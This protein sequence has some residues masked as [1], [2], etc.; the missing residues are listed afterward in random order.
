MQSLPGL[1][2][3][4]VLCSTW[5]GVGGEWDS[6]SKC[7]GPAAAFLSGGSRTGM[8]GRT[9]GVGGLGRGPVDLG[10]ALVRAGRMNAA[11]SLRVAGS[12]SMVALACKVHST[13]LKVLHQA[14]EWY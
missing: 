5:G 8:A 3:C 14:E 4:S 9:P 10:L 12:L 13:V 7:P 1:Q 2:L 6:P 11:R